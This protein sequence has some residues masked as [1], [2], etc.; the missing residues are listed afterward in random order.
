MFKDTITYT[1]YTD[2]KQKTKDFYF[3][4][5]KADII[6]IS[7]ALPGGIDGFLER[8]ND[9][10]R[11]EDVI[12]V[13]EKIILKAYGKRTADNKFIKSKELSEEFMASDAY[14]ELFIKFINNE[15]DYVDKFLA[16]TINV[17]MDEIKKL[18][19]SEEVQKVTEAMSD[20]L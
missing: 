13:F 14:S 1:S 17:S 5:T 7:A 10:P 15:N 16:G 18:G 19:E 3:N 4:L 11:A 2:G 20:T 8:L 9:E 6:S 12:D